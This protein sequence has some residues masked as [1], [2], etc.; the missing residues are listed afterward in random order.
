MSTDTSEGAQRRTGS[1]PT[2]SVND[3]KRW[4][5]YQMPPIMQDSEL[6]MPQDPAVPAAAARPRASSKPTPLPANPNFTVPVTGASGVST[7]GRTVSADSQPR[8]PVFGVPITGP[9]PEP[10]KSMRKASTMSDTKRL[11][12]MGEDI[13]ASVVPHTGGYVPPRRQSRSQS[14]ANQTKRLSKRFSTV[15]VEGEEIEEPPTRPTWTQQPEI[16]LTE[17][18]EKDPTNPL[19]WRRQKKVANTGVAGKHFIHGSQIG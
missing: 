15:T 1:R 12:T 14:V 16:D 3:N 6:F 4:S 18:W 2:N 9:N 8:N 13:V 10:Q 5:Q 11:S 17:P 7:L 19:N